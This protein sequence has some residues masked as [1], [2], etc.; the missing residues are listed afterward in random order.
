M[1]RVGEERIASCHI[2]CASN[3]HS[4]LLLALEATACALSGLEDRITWH[5]VHVRSTRAK[6]KRPERVSK[7]GIELLTA[8]RVALI[9]PSSERGGTCVREL[10]AR[11]IT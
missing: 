8:V 11:P 4:S 7:R 6:A 3:I 9:A 2:E 1:R 10:F 5:T